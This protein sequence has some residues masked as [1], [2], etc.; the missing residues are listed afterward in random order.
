MLDLQKFSSN[1]TLFWVIIFESIFEVAIRYNIHQLRI[2]HLLINYDKNP[3]SNCLNQILSTER[4]QSKLSDVFTKI[5]NKILIDK[6]KLFSCSFVFG[7]VFTSQLNNSLHLSYRVLP[8]FFNQTVILGENAT[9]Y[10]DA[11][12]SVFFSG[13]IATGASLIINAT[14][15][16]ITK[17]SASEFVLQDSSI[18]LNFVELNS[19]LDLLNS[20]LQI[21]NSKLNADFEF[22]TFY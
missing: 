15:N 8:Y 7:N 12:V 16:S 3:S 1:T 2:G 9:L 21:A 10:I 22:Q 20:N 14:K 5:P 13:L 18:Y 4:E 11:G 6:I 19:S 17:I